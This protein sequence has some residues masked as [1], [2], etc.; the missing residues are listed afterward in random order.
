MGAQLGSSGTISDINMTPLIDIVL[1]V[2]I[3]MMV[4][5]P[6]QVEE[7]GVK[8]PSTV[9]N[10]PPPKE[11][12]EQL[13]IAV[14]EDERVALNKRVMNNDVLF[15]EVTRRLRP[16]SKKIVFIDAHPE[17][18]Y[19][20]VIDMMDLAREAGAE[21]VAF[22]KLKELGPSE[23]TSVAPGAMPR[24]VIA[25]SPSVVGEMTEKQADTHFRPMLPVAKSC[26]ASALGAS[27]ELSGRLI[28]RVDV[29][30]QGEIMDSG[31]VA[32]GTTLEDQ[33]VIDCIMEQVPA[34]EYPELGEQKTARVHY[35]LLFSPG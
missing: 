7:M 19:G 13:V 28:V 35:P 4:N 16:M 12:I 23:P 18:P 14:Y 8:L 33:G 9:V 3:I 10:N 29:G 30:P 31:V 27:P 24:G 6:I 25:G 1:V 17:L 26:Y 11:K 34:L 20:I 32:G 22:A 15:Y 2:L 5:I 21:K